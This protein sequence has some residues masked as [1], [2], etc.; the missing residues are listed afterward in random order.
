MKSQNYLKKNLRKN[1]LSLPEPHPSI[2]YTDQVEGADIFLNRSEAF[3]PPSPK[4]VEALSENA[5]LANRY[6]DSACTALRHKLAQYVETGMTPEQIIV[7]NGSDGLI[8]LLVKTFVNPQEEVIVPAP[9]FFV[10][11]HAT[12]LMGGNLVEQGRTGAAEGFEIDTDE[13]LKNVT[14]DTRLIFLANPNNPTGNTIDRTK[15]ETILREVE[16]MVVLDECYYEVSGET[17][18]DLVETYGNLII[19]RS[20]SK[21]FGLAGLRVGYCISNREIISFLNRADQTFPV[22]RFA[23]VAAEAALEDLAYRDAC[24]AELKSERSALVKGLSALGFH[25]YPSAA[26]FLLVNWGQTLSTNPVTRLQ[27]ARV[28][29]AD[30]HSKPGLEHCFRT[31]VSNSVENQTFLDALSNIKG[32]FE[33]SL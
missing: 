6:P 15:I 21:G 10:Y 8:E 18:L 2:Y 32:V 30:F 22:N 28:F 4:V 33:K 5:S 24:I 14:D 9:S 29:V 1:I 3:F 31:G 23:L 17:V 26:N 20:L 16:C 19:L 7:G 25:V 13:V 12:Q 27:E 11:V